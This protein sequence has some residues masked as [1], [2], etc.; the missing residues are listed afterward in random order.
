M[1]F[2]SHAQ[3]TQRVPSVFNENVLL[4]PAGLI[5]EEASGVAEPDCRV[6][7]T[8]LLPHHSCSDPNISRQSE[9]GHQCVSANVCPRMERPEPKAAV[10]TGPF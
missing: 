5:F 3:A 4:M 2:V 7:V 8:E 9:T 10:A 1:T 6:V